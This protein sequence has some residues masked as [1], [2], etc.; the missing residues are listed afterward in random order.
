MFRGFNFIL[1]V[2]YSLCN[3]QYWHFV[4]EKTLTETIKNTEIKTKHVI[5]MREAREARKTQTIIFF[6]P[7][8]A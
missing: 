4:F 5:S 1:H 8:K 2:C 6:V 7:L 3:K